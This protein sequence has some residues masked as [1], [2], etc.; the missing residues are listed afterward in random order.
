MAGETELDAFRTDCLYQTVKDLGSKT[1][2]ITDAGD[3]MTEGAKGPMATAERISLMLADM[4]DPADADAAL[5]Y[6]QIELLNVLLECEEKKPGCVAGLSPTLEAFRAA[7][8]ARPRIAKYL[9]SPMR[10]PRIVPGYKYAAGPIK[11]ST[12]AV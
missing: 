5:N 3:G 6:G 10:F 2:E 9:A 11:R 7:A 12:L 8:A 4:V 1:S